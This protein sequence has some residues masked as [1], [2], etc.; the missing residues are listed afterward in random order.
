MHRGAFYRK[1]IWLVWSRYLFIFFGELNKIVHTKSVWNSTAV[2]WD[3]KKV[4]KK[5]SQKE[6]HPVFPSNGYVIEV[7][8]LQLWNFFEFLFVFEHFRVFEIRAVSLSC[9]PISATHVVASTEIVCSC[10][11][12]ND[13]QCREN[14]LD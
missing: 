10:V 9:N 11:A 12:V 5:M 14:L 2:C 7:D 4:D 3:R 1:L 6:R 8:M 13:S